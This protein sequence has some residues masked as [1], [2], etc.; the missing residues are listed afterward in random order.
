MECDTV[1]LIEPELIN[2]EIDPLEQPES[3]IEKLIQKH[4]K[5]NSTQRT[6]SSCQSNDSV[7]EGQM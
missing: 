6:S 3:N 2:D 5:Y 7:D 1:R 4:K